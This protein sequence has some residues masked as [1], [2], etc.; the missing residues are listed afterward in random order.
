MYDGQKLNSV[1]Y[2]ASLNPHI[3][4]RSKREPKMENSLTWSKLKAREGTRGTVTSLIQK[5][6][7]TDTPSNELRDTANSST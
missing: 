3:E 7:A 5:L 2:L 4:T 1:A 6:L